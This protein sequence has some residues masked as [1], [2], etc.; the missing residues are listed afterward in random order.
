MKL[1]TILLMLLSFSVVTKETSYKITKVVDKELRM[2]YLKQCKQ[3]KQKD[4]HVRSFNQAVVFK[5]I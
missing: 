5:F 1:I 2:K 4:C 3:Q